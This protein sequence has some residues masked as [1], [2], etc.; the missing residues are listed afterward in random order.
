MPRKGDRPLFDWNIGEI[1]FVV[2]T[3]PIPTDTYRNNN[4]IN[5]VIVS[6]ARWDDPIG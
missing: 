3:I 5:V 1:L 6:C 2:S 4:V